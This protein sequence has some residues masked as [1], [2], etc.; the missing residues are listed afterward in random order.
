MSWLGAVLLMLVP[1]VQHLNIDIDVDSLTRH[2]RSMYC[3]SNWAC[4]T[5]RTFFRGW[6]HKP[7]ELLGEQQ[8]PRQPCFCW[9]TSEPFSEGGKAHAQVLETFM[10]HWQQHSQRQP[11][12]SEISKYCLSNSK[13]RSH[14]H[15]SSQC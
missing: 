8:T 5:H 2:E 13:A 6:H 15:R 7:W 4:A 11:A 10:V 3:K 14:V 9:R 12:H 1:P